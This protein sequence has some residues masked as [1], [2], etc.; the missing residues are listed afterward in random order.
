MLDLFSTFASSAEPDERR[1]TAGRLLFEARKLAGHA[2]LGGN[3]RD[4]FSAPQGSNYKT[5]GGQHVWTWPETSFSRENYLDLSKKAAEFICSDQLASTIEA[6]ESTLNQIMGNAVQHSNSDNAFFAA[7]R[8][9]HYASFV[10]VDK[11]IGVKETFSD[12]LASLD[13]THAKDRVSETALR[14][15]MTECISSSDDTS[16]NRGRGLPLLKA[17][18]SSA[19]II[20]DGA[21]YYTRKGKSFFPVQYWNAIKDREESGQIVG[22]KLKNLADFG[23]IVEAYID[24]GKMGSALSHTEFNCSEVRDEFIRTYGSDVAAIIFKS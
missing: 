22:E 24:L 13:S 20:S 8:T 4:H 11:G 15:A 16:T 21:Y 5:P 1:A 23:V 2:H 12:A 14:W 19:L 3:L 9:E 18:C 17:A 7:I 6:F 10:V